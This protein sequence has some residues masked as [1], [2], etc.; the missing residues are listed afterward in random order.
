MG[1]YAVR[2]FLLIIPTVFIIT[3]LLFLIIRLIPGDVVQ[4]IAAQ[5]TWATEMGTTEAV[6]LDEIRAA[7]GLDKP[8]YVQYG[9]W[10]S[11]FFRG[12]FGTSVWTGRKLV[13]ELKVR[14]PVTV[15]LSIISLILGLL[16]SVPLGI[17]SAIR[18]DTV[19]DYTGRTVSIL[20]LAIPSFWI[21]TVVVVYPVVYWGKSII[22]IEYI[23]FSQNP[24]GN[25]WQFFLISVIM[26]ATTAGGTV[27]ITR[28]MMLEVMRQDYIRTAWSKGLAEKLV[29]FRHA[30]KNTMIPVV[31]IIGGM[32]PGLFGGA[33][34]METIF[35]LPGLGRYFLDSTVNRDYLIVSGW[36]LI[37]STF[38]LIFIVLTDLAYAYVDPRI[39]YK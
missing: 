3:V 19:L 25:L 39:R 8:W 29:V 24:L 5:R 13:D 27:R 30:V 6:S 21:A 37:M 34:I 31:T 1:A 38:V 4:M 33:V 10:I 12:D 16:M 20:L 26:A 9:N 18:Q 17:Y 22:P 11:G 36:N 32:I 2:R 23:P 14:A 15:E 35:N 28:T 7:F